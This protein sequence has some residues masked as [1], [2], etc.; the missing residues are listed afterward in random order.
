MKFSD[1]NKIKRKKIVAEIIC[2]AL[3][4]GE[5]TGIYCMVI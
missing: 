1:N 3:G 4:G 2:Q 5:V